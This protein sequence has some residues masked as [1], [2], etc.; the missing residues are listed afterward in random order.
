M[1]TPHETKRFEAAAAAYEKVKET[2]EAMEVEHAAICA[3]LKAALKELDD[4]PALTVP[5]EDLKAAL[6]DYFSEIGRQHGERVRGFLAQF[7]V[8]KIT[9]G[10]PVPHAEM[11]KPLRFGHLEALANKV[12][13]E[14][15]FTHILGCGSPYLSDRAVAF[16]AADLLRAALGRVLDSLSPEDL[17]YGAIHPDKIGTDRATRRAAIDSCHA[18]IAALTGRL[19]ELRVKLRALG[20][21]CPA[22]DGEV[23]GKLHT[24]GYTVSA[25]YAV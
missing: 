10:A 14:A 4:L 24:L 25:G 1:D 6:L 19:N 18:R 13:G 17:G 3:E 7:A 20:R 16:F 2:A 12:D 11:G 8:G 23:A 21:A 15:P 5:P 22:L 9:A